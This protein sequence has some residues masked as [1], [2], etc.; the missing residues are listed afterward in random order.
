MR[1]DASRF[2]R[3]RGR[4]ETAKAERSGQSDRRERHDDQDQAEAASGGWRLGS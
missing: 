2:T 1:G 4:G 3:V